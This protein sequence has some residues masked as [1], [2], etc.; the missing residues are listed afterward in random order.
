MK[1]SRT[2]VCCAVMIIALH[3]CSGS[4]G[5]GTKR[6]N[7]SPAPVRIDAL[8]AS[9]YWLARDAAKAKQPL[10]P[11]YVRALLADGRLTIGLGIGTEDLGEVVIPEEPRDRVCKQ[12]FM[13]CGCTVVVEGRLITTNDEFTAALGECEL[14][15]IQSHSRFGAGPVFYYEGKA[16]P[17]RMQDQQ[18]YEIR[19]PEDEVSGYHG[20]VMHAYFDTRRGKQYTVFAPDSTDLDAAVP[21]HGYQVVVLSTCTSLKHFRDTISRF[22]S[23]YPTTAIFTTQPCCMDT[24]ME[25][26][27]SFLA[28]VFQGKPVNAVVQDMNRTY[29][30][31]AERRVK[32]KIPPWKVV[33]HL[34]TVGINTFP[35]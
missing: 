32:M 30:A 10:C 9:A 11:E 13:L 15:F 20:K 12:K 25:V 34:Y 16:R 28:A 4:G 35:E 22:R 17:Y 18:H 7:A 1:R 6:S 2:L 29:Q 24:S 3:G 5:T 21:L 27:I 31:F 33:E 26:F 19:M 8:V 14:L 23:S